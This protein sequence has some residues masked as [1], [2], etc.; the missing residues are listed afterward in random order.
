MKTSAALVIFG[1]LL[2]LAPLASAA[3]PQIDPKNLEVGCN[4]DNAPDLR[5]TPGRLRIRDG[6]VP[7]VPCDKSNMGYRVRKAMMDLGKMIGM[8]GDSRW[9][10]SIIGYNPFDFVA[11]RIDFLEIIYEQ[12]ES[13]DI[14]TAGYFHRNDET[15]RGLEN[16]FKFVTICPSAQAGTELD[17]M[18]MM[19]HEAWHA[20]GNFH[21]QCNHGRNSRI[22]FKGCD[23]SIEYRGAYAVTL[24]FYLT[25]MKEPSLTPAQRQ[26]ARGRSIDTLI[27][28]FNKLPKDLNYVAVT[29]PMS[30]GAYVFDGQREIKL[31]GQ[32]PT[33]FEPTSV[34]D[35]PFFLNKVSKK[36]R[37][38]AYSGE[39]M[40]E[41]GSVLYRWDDKVNATFIDN[42]DL[43][44]M[45]CYLFTHQITCYTRDGLRNVTYTVSDRQIARFM[46]LDNSLINKKD[47]GVTAFIVET[48]GETTAVPTNY[49]DFK[50]LGVF[51]VKNNAASKLAAVWRDT[52]V[53]PKDASM[54][55][56]ML[57][58]R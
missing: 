36:M 20:E 3:P 41:F 31:I 25:A 56:P 43:G 32:L 46:V 22:K 10:K 26:D 13:C 29:Y 39:R 50:K 17:I 52:I 23:P 58:I 42:A 44:D 15:G 48:D 24:E 38:Y 40:P 57:F 11:K 53:F 12:K 5:L 14:N 8:N 35:K 18:M 21:E 1:L 54:P 7:Y 55:Y 49:E 4:E 6:A 30:G 45:S 37:P 16:Q 19:L 9:G 51:E 2:Q 33:G 28:N 34:T 47:P 27:S